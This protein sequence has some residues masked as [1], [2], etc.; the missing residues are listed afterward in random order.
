VVQSDE[1]AT[2]ALDALL[3][4]AVASRMISDVPLGAFL[5]GGIDS[6]TVV[7]LMQA[8]SSR[9]VRTFSI[10]F[11]HEHNE[12]EHAQAVARHLGTDHT[13]LYVEGED[14]LEV[15]DVLPIVFDEPFADASQIPT[16]IISR[17]AR[18]H[19]TV[20]L[21][22]DGGDELFFG[23]R[24]YF[25]GRKICP[26]LQSSPAVLRRRLAAVV[27]RAGASEPGEGKLHGLVADL[28]ATN[29]GAMFLN[30]V[31]RW[32]N[33]SALVVGGNEPPSAFDRVFEIL[34]GRGD[35]LGSDRSMMLVDL[36]TYLT[37]DILVKV[38]RTSMA[39]SL[40]V[41]APLL[42]YRVV[43]MASR[44]P[45]E[46]KFR[47]GKGKWILRQV[48][49]RHVP[50]ELTDRPKL[51]FGAPIRQWLRGALREW[52]EELLAADRLEREGYFH[53]DAIRSMWQENLSGRRKWHNHLWPV[54]M[55]QAW[56]EHQRTAGVS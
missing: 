28:E 24:R 12:A 51:G 16:L 11:H 32:K 50:T 31:S 25:R 21:S 4:D 56:L 44:L 30:R 2:D 20:A 27:R 49:A 26:A 5:S 40:E 53:S 13:E 23:Y 37:D 29:H 54:L 7:A 39:A 41:R 3:S 34:S 48:L 1:Q 36:S 52:G 8:Q 9:P 18:E 22:G 6:S 42:D 33:P 46:L 35:L 43:E 10:G 47:D 55:F 14:T 38:D 19:V 17:L 15:V 45:M